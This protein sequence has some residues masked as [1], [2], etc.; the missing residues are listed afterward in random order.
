MRYI[1]GSK[2]EV[3]SQKEVPSG[4][5]HGAEIICGNGHNY[6]VW[7]DTCAGR[8]DDVIFKRVSRK[9]IRPCPPISEV[10]ENWVSGDIVEVFDNFCW[11]MAAI[12]KVL[13]K[14]CFLVRLL[15]S[16]QE[17]KVNKSY[18]RPRFNWQDGKWVVSGKGSRDCGN[19]KHSEQSALMC[20]QISSSQFRRT[21]SLSYLLA[22]DDD[23]FAVGEKMHAHEIQNRSSR[24][25]KKRALNYDS[26]A[27][28]CA[29]AAH[30][31]RLVHARCGV[32]AAVATLLPKVDAVASSYEMMTEINEH[33]SL[34]T[35]TIF[36]EME[37]ERLKPSGATRNLPDISFQPNDSYSVSSS[38]GSCSIFGSVPYELPRHSSTYPNG[39][40]DGNS[41]D[42]Q[43]VSQRDEKGDSFLPTEKELAEKIHS[44]ELHA[45][46]CTM[47]ALHASGPLSWEQEA[48]VTNLRLSLHI[49]NDEHL[50]ELRNLVSTEASIPIR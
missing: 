20:N 16:L 46:R 6:T 13:R 40:S 11:K 48:L 3:F 7:Y 30:K 2:V 24:T 25:S 4:S 32:K 14:K 35:G 18:L 17:F 33:A 22:R 27:E 44:L 15:G 45:Y 29:G 28:A 47:E 10:T 8:S 41:S 38:V 34:K 9:V 1:R 49:S 39:D 37:I 23:S 43:S 26:P 36:S 42:A 50:L 12:S 31:Y 21:D 5:W 19:H